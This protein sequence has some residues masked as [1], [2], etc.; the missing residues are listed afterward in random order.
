MVIYLMCIVF[1]AC[2]TNRPTG[3][4]PTNPTN[5]A[6]TGSAGLK[7]EMNGDGTYTVVG[8]GSCTDPD[9][10]IPAHHQGGKVS[11]IGAVAFYGCDALTS[12]TVEEGITSI[13]YAAFSGCSSLTAVTLPASTITIGDYA[14]ENCRSLQ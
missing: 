4:Q 13:G 2:E 7:Y 8:L 1:C 6:E 10:Y 3:G 5:P 12:I 14:F 9:V 11:S